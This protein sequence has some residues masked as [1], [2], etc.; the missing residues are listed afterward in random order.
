MTHYTPLITILVAGFGLAF[1]FGYL[2]HRLHISPIV[3]Y[4]L[5]GVLIVINP[6]L[7]GFINKL[8]PEKSYS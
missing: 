2:A 3:G 4:L 7:F 1:V 6:F 8:M 5:A